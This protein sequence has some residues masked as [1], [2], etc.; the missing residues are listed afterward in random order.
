M[1]NTINEYLALLKKDIGN[2]KVQYVN[3]MSNEVTTLIDIGMTGGELNHEF[4]ITAVFDADTGLMDITLDDSSLS[5]TDDIELKSSEVLTTVA[6]I[7]YYVLNDL[8]NDL[9]NS[10]AN[11]DEIID[12]INNLSIKLSK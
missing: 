10:S 4:S 3:G 11:V 9:V 1:R 6:A 8:L 5:M 7:R 12:D 2:I